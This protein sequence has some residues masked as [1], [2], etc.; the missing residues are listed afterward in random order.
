MTSED[1]LTFYPQFSQ[2]PEAVLEDFIRAANER[3]EFLDTDADFARRLFVAHRLTLYARTSAVSGASAEALS[4]AGE[5]TMITGKHV[6]ELSVS[7][8]VRGSADSH[9][10]L[11]LTT[12]GVQLNAL[13]RIHGYSRYVP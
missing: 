4:S 9:S 13:L 3:F 2:M 7:Y 10:D 11:S 5:N 1:F 6:G 12:Y 8:A